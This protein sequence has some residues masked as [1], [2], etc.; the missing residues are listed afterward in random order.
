M[1]I[2][3]NLSSRVALAANLTPR[4]L[5][6]SLLLLLAALAAC[7]TSESS[8]AG[9]RAE[10]VW[11][12]PASG[13]GQQGQG[14][15]GSEG[16]GNGDSSGQKGGNGSGQGAG[17]SSGQ[18]QMMQHGQGN[19]S[20]V[21]M[22]LVNAGQETDRLVA[23]RTDVAGVVEIHETRMEGEVMT[24]QHLPDGLEIPAGETV[25]LKPGGY[26][27]MLIDLQQDLEVGDKFEIVLEFEMAGEQTVKAEVREP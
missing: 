9:V 21:Y 27:I 2:Y 15:G 3:N 7:G 14:L 16:G 18:G 8:E 22:R 4:I 13:M 25:E 26:H 24:M 1:G 23:A 20:A 17:G 11:S 6:I 10:D 12:R 19:T 5:L